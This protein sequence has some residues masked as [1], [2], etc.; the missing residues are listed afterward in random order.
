VVAA[1]GQKDWDNIGDINELVLGR[2]GNVKAVVLGVGGFL[3]MGEKNVAVSMKDLMFVK[4][5]DGPDDYSLVINANK[6]ALNAAPAYKTPDDVKAALNAAK[7]TD[8]TTTA[9]NPGLTAPADDTTAANTTPTTDMAKPADTAADQ[10]SSTATT[11]DNTAAN[12]EMTK[13]ADTASDQASSTTTQPAD[14]SS[15]QASST[16]TE[17]ADQT[18]SRTATTD[19]AATDTA[20]NTEMKKPAD[21]ANDQASSAA[22]PSDNNA[23]ATDTTTTASTTKDNTA[24]QTTMTENRARLTP[25]T[26]TREGYQAAEVKELTADKLEGAR[27]YGPK[28][29]DV[30][31]I[32]RLVMNDD[33]QVKLFVL[34]IG[35]FLGIGEHRIAVTPEELNIVRNAKGDDFRVYIDA[36]KQALKAQPEYKVQ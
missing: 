15:D 22:T 19:K 2:D 20:A 14:A 8:M 21:T 12:T 1:D 31:E 24:V 3:G 36:N 33:G 7:T 35:G 26:V 30:G 18:A 28:D 4:T 16:T 13:P 11:T 23:A 17:P 5:G 34:D 29:E 27:L 25:P 32:N 10:A 9:A 6:E